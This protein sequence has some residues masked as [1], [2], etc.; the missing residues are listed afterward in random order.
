MEAI[1]YMNILRLLILLD[2]Q[3]PYLFNIL[4]VYISIIYSAHLHQLFNNF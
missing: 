3:Q 4:L 1:T 2:L